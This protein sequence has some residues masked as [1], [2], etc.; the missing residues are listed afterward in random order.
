MLEVEDWT[1]SLA[2]PTI[3]LPASALLFRDRLALLV[4]ASALP[5][6]GPFLE[7]RPQ[8]SR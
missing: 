1:L 6:L 3:P 8:L 4:P 5:L 2:H 7:Q